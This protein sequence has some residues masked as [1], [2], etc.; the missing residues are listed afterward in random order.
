[1][2]A[3]VRCLHAAVMDAGEELTRGRTAYSTRAWLSAYD[4][5][6]RADHGAPLG[7][8]DLEALAT[9]AYMLG[10]EDDYVRTLERAYRLHLDADESLRAARCAFWMGLTLMLRGGSGRAAGWLGRALR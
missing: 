9:S 8:D 4:A 10:R 5:L 7:A 2:R 3:A 1:M 6:S